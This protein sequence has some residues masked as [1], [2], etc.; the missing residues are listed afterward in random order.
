VAAAPQPKQP[1]G[2]KNKKLVGRILACV[3]V[4]AARS[5]ICTPT[6]CGISMAR[7]WHER[8]SRTDHTW[9]PRAVTVK[10]ISMR[11]TLQFVPFAG[12][13]LM[14]FS[15]V[16]KPRIDI[17]INVKGR[18]IGQQSIPQFAFLRAA[19][20]AAVQKDFVE[21]NR[22][23]LPLDYAPVMVR[24]PLPPP[25]RC[26]SALDASW[27]RALPDMCLGHVPPGTV[28]RGTPQKGGGGSPG[29]LDQASDTRP[30]VL[31][32][33]LSWHGTAQGE[34][35]ASR[36]RVRV[37]AVR[38]LSEADSKRGDVLEHIAGA[39]HADEQD[40]IAIEVGNSVRSAHTSLLQ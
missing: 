38:G 7:K 10:G 30:K 26:A 15:F 40:G 39:E 25:T 21:P 5:H 8:S 16:E 4:A 32:H 37:L 11:G 33:H 34:P 20:L 2:R 9:R 36:V 28:F 12:A 6:P 18:F 24:P 17:K 29:F 31:H 35:L 13:R 14:L 19:I 1:C 23:V 3:I 22:A 27:C